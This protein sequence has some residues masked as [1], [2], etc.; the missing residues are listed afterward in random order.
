MTIRIVA[1]ADNHL[2]I[3]SM[4]YGAKKEERRKDFKRSF[5]QIVEYALKNKAQVFLQGG[6]LFD[7]MAPSNS[8]RAWTM[9]EFRRLHEAGIFVFVVSGHHDTPRGITTGASP[10]KTHGDSG[11]ILFFENPS[12]PESQTIEIDGKTVQVVGI[13]YNPTLFPDQDPMD[14]PIPPAKGDIN[15]LLVHHP[16]S[17]FSGYIGDEPSVDPKKIPEGYQLVVAG[18]FHSPQHKRIKETTVIYPGSSER[19]DFH[20]ETGDKSFSWIEVN[21]QGKI[22]VRQVPLTTR[23]LKTEAVRVS[24][25]DDI[26]QVVRSRIEKL[27]NP[28]LICRV[29][30]EGTIPAETLATYKRTPLQ[31]YGDEVLF[32]VFIEESG[33]HIEGPAHIEPI[34]SANPDEELLHYFEAKLEDVKS[35][36]ERRIVE[37]A[38]KLCLEKLEEVRGS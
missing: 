38:K 22:V 27:A 3:S 30:L 18:H 14:V 23:T 24:P 1:T 11:H 15:I 21:D 36:E 6:D 29:Q 19:V 20:E 17:G 33:L 4:K 5:E 26:S 7:S 2:D 37:N 13:G 35:D 34:D 32:K 8:T 31:R 10:L 12:Q 28:E 16:I 25:G 9:R